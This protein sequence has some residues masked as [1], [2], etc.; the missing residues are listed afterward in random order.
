MTALPPIL[1]TS[2]AAWPVLV[3]VGAASGP[4]VALGAVV[5]GGLV[6]SSLG[7][8]VFAGQRFVASLEAQQGGGVW[9]SLLLSKS[10]LVLAAFVALAERLPPQ[11]LALGLCTLLVG[12]F[13]AA[14]LPREV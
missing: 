4:S 10:A 8:G 7:V 5:A 1:K 12:A 9:G 2:A 14:L 6:I 13:G 11:G 3:G